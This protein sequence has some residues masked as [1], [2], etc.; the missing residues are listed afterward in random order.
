MVSDDSDTKD[1]KE[2]SPQV[3]GGCAFL[4]SLIVL[5]PCGALF[6]VLAALQASEA[7]AL[8]TVAFIASVI[9]GVFVAKYGIRGHLSV[10]LHEFKHSLISNFVGNKHKGMKIGKN[11]GHY[12]YTYTKHTAHYNAMIAL[13]PYITPIFS[14]VSLA[15]ALTVLRHDMTLAVSMIGLGYGIDLHLNVRDI[16]PIQTDISLIRGGYCV[17]LLYIFAWNLLTLALVLALAFKGPAGVLEIVDTIGMA[18]AKG[19]L[20]LSGQAPGE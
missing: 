4:L 5:L 6:T 3:V 10:L 18:L 8:P 15:L 7:E 20:S 2:P 13:A 17:G 11:S 19:Y 12:E 9:V 14:L 1:D 16:S